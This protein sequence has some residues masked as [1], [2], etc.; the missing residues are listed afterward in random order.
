MNVIG[1]DPGASGAI[2]LLRSGQ[3][4]RVLDMPTVKVGKRRRVI[5]DALAAIVRDMAPDH[6]FVELVASM[7]SDGHVGAFTFGKSTGIIHGVLAGLLVPVS[8]I[9]PTRWK[10]AMQVNAD[11]GKARARASQL[12][13][14]HSESW[15]RVMDD[16]RAEA[17]MIGLF[18]WRVELGNRMI[19]W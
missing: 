7:P 12:F 18:G 11:K 13:P 8:E 14:G 10:P 4:V 2:A 3:L 5:P 1:I 16:G 6:A 17:A 9:A 19:E 15:A